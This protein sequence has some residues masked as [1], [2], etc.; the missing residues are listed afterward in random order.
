[1]FGKAKEGK[2]VQLRSTSADVAFM[3]LCLS[4][5]GAHPLALRHLRH[6][7]RK[8]D[9]YHES[10]EATRILRKHGHQY[11]GVLVDGLGTWL[12]NM[13]TLKVNVYNKID[14]LCQSIRSLDVPVVV[15]NSPS[16]DGRHLQIVKYANRQM[17]SQSR[18]I[19]SAEGGLIVRLK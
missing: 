1:M 16:A 3:Y 11:C 6:R 14:G 4:A 15:S 5:P 2:S 9:I 18:R 19:Y 10:A 7:E 12:A 8:W 17:A 13:L